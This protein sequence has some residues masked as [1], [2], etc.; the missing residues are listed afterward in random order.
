MC[1]IHRLEAKENKF[2]LVFL[3]SFQD[4]EVDEEFE[5]IVLASDGLWDVVPNEVNLPHPN[6]QF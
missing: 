6:C 5:F 3:F 1:V 2:S 4:Q